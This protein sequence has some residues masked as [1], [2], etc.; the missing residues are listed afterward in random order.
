MRITPQG[1][2]A[3]VA[4][5]MFFCGS[6]AVVA[7]QPESPLT[8]DDLLSA[9]QLTDTP[10]SLSP[11]GEWLAYT[12]QDPRR[13]A[14]FDSEQLPF[15]AEGDRT[16][17]TGSDIWITATKTGTS[18]KLT[19][20]I[21]SSW[22]PVWSPNGKYLAFYSTRGGNTNVWIYDV[23]TERLRCA[24]QVPAN[25]FG[26]EAVAWTPDSNRLLSKLATDNKPAAN[27]LDR[28]P[29]G[30]TLEHHLNSRVTL[31]R[32]LPTGESRNPSGAQDPGS[33]VED[34]RTRAEEADL[35]LI[36]VSS[37]KVERIAR[38]F[39]PVWYRPSPDGSQIALASYKGLRGGN[40]YRLAAA[41]P[42]TSAHRRF[43]HRPE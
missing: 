12:L 33:V 21:G 31:Y 4:F 25:P 39:N 9:L 19:G 2:T 28:K 36:D 6:G 17:A 3:L 1:F 30:G 11:D 10:G 16:G 7:Q 34:S 5:S 42:R 20:G 27:D 15:G 26:S 38:G 13:T 14:E 37:G 22:A 29:S 8:V 35:D 23:R 18:S 41:H 32:S 40:R 24:S 43:R